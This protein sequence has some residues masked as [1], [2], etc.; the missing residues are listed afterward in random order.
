MVIGAA[1]K[2]EA[3]RQNL[4]RSLAK[5]QAIELHPLFQDAKDQFVLLGP[6]DVVDMLLPGQVDQFGHRHLLQGGDVGITPLQ[7][8]IAIGRIDAVEFH[9]GGDL[10]RQRHRLQIQV[11]PGVFGIGLRHEIPRGADGRRAPACP[12]ESRA[13]QG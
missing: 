10:L 13:G 7:A 9:F 3:I 8:I 2:A 12:A 6:D 11:F 4:Q 1:Q 5:H